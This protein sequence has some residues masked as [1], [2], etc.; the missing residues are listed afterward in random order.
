MHGPH[1]RSEHAPFTCLL[2]NRGPGLPALRPARDE[3]CQQYSSTYGQ[4]GSE[5][6]RR[7]RGAI[8]TLLPVLLLGAL[9]GALLAVYTLPALT[10]FAACAQPALA[11]RVLPARLHVLLPQTCP[12]P[13]A[14]Y[15][16]FGAWPALQARVWARYEQLAVHAASAHASAL[17]HLR[18]CS[19]QGHQLW[20]DASGSLQQRY[21]LGQEKAQELHQR[22]QA[23]AQEL[24]H[25]TQ[26]LAQELFQ[27]T[28]ALAHELVQRAQALAQKAAARVPIGQGASAPPAAS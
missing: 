21:A 1:W 5:E 20:Q 15:S 19:A 17:A 8:H 3:L 10:A 6:P 24:F 7:R 22:A 13:Q 28:Q 25:R 16:A 14:A 2:Q 27:R 18:S 11:A 12:A 23:L 9:L 26:A 4:R